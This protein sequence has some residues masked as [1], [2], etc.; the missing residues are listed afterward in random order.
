MNER[1]LVPADPQPQFGP[2]APA[3][4]RQAPTPGLGAIIARIEETIDT[5]TASI[6]TDAKFD[7]RAS[8]ARKSRHLYELNK[9]LKNARSPAQI[10][11]HRE[12]ITRLRAKLA[13]NEAAI[14]AHLS[15]VGEVA[16]LLRDAIARADADGTYSSD[17]FGRTG[18]T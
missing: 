3:G 2:E 6:R 16:A 10:E 11:Q 15:A 8:N 12:E 18:S 14:K 7:I 4:A 9:A 17:S 1:N 5:E 13:S